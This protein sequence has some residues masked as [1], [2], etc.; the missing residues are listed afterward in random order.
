MPV[1]SVV[2]S[3]DPV[4]PVIGV[5]HDVAM[6]V[7]A[8]LRS[9]RDEAAA[10]LAQLEA[11][12]DPTFVDDHLEISTT[13]ASIALQDVEHALARFDDGTYGSCEVCGGAIPVER[14]EVIPSATTCVACAVA[15]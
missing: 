14:L 5:N 4:R 6:R 3:A 2:P 7:R 11:A 1:A 12:A 15:R 9:R 8:L 13:A 10:R